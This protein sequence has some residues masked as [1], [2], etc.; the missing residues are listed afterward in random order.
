MP[1]PF[2]LEKIFEERHDPT[3]SSMGVPPMSSQKKMRETPMLLGRVWV[4]QHM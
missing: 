2:A 1:E 4:R 3:I